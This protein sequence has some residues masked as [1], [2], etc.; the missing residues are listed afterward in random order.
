MAAGEWTQQHL[1]ATVSVGTMKLL[2]ALPGPC[3]TPEVSAGG[4]M[5]L[6]WCSAAGEVQQGE[7]PR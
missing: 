4:R 5:V 1:F 6:G 7:E 3:R 2:E